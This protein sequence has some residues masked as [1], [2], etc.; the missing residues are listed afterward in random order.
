MAD[1]NPTVAS[2]K[3]GTNAQTQRVTLG[4][5]VTQ[6]MCV[7]L[8]TSDNEYKIADCTTSPTTAA[9]V[10]I[11]L[12]AGADGQPG[13]IQTD[14]YVTFGADLT[15]NTIYVLSTGGMLAPA[16][17]FSAVTDYLTVVGCAVSTTSLKLGINATG[18]GKTG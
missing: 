3:P 12:S 7:Y 2:V 18:S 8:D 1:I 13:V 10:G 17:D 6:G 14:G 5:T 9:V 15:A 4:A 11:A 16:A